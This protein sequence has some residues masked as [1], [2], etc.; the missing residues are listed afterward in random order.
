MQIST[1]KKS[2]F[3]K[4]VQE[5]IRKIFFIAFKKS[6]VPRMLTL[7]HRE[8]VGTSKFWRKSKENKLFFSFEN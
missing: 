5:K 4:T 2:K 1:I 3:W 6:L 7:S 8:N